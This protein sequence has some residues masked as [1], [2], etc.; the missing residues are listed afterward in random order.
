[1]PY[2]GKSPHFGVRNR[3]VYT[4]SG[5]ETSKSGADDS[6][7]TLTFTDG[8]YVDVY[9]NGVLLKPDT[10]YVTTTAN[11][12]GSLSA[13][14]ASDILEVIVYD[15]FSVS[16]TVSAA[17]G[18]TFQGAV[19]F[20]GGV[21]T[22][23]TPSSA[24]GVALGS[25][26]LEWSDL[27]LADSGVIYF[28]N[29]QEITLTHS[30]DSG[31]ILKHTA[32]ADDKPATLTLQTGET[33]IAVNDVLGAIYFQA[34]DEATGTDAQA[35]AG[36]IQAVSEGDFSSSNN[37]TSLVL[38][39]GASESATEKVRID[40]GGRVGIGNTSPSTFSYKA[41]IGSG[42]AE[43]RL[44]FYSS[45][46]DDVLSGLQWADGTSGA[47]QYRGYFLYEHYSNDFWMGMDAGTK[48]R[49]WQSSGAAITEC[50]AGVSLA[51]D[52]SFSFRVGQG[53][54]VVSNR[55]NGRVALYMID[56]TASTATEIS[57]PNS[58]T[59]NSDSDGSLCVY[60]SGANSYDVTIKNRTGVTIAVS[61]NVFSTNY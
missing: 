36:A 18:G 10:D 24:D 15:V 29:D 22:A 44:T 55:S 35:I 34:P 6:G 13:L 51:D 61:A 59:A 1:M 26:S 4:A 49:F 17:S 9:L 53:I 20:N 41:I 25:A 32:T 47:D 8:A 33:D 54:L 11:T 19:G 21:S 23:L 14:T 39:T 3:F 50:Q 30:A 2:I 57:D 38:K 45:N 58:T 56:Y 27:Y 40:S 37:A 31:L 5:S 46:S 12:I 60:K 48:Y 43:E 7:A 16:D 28:G 42:S 52:A